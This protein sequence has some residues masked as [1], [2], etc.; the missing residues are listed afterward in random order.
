MRV[1]KKVAPTLRANAKSHEPVVFPNA[2]VL[3]DQGGG[4]GWTYAKK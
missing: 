1:H 3:N 2:V 4:Q